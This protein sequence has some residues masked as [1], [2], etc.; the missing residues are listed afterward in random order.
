MQATAPITA[1]R[2]STDENTLTIVL[3]DRTIQI[4]WSECSDKLA[5]AGAEQRRDAELSPGGYG[6]HWPQL[7]EDLSVNG[8]VLAYD[9]RT[10]P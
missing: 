2:I 6:I 1:V 3:A 9:S 8:L 5:R 7:D 4:P 10:T